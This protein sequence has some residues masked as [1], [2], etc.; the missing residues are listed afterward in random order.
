M[1]FAVTEYAGYTPV[2]GLLNAQV[3]S[4]TQLLQ[5]NG[6]QTTLGINSFRYEQFKQPCTAMDTSVIGFMNT[7][8]TAKD[9]IQSA[10]NSSNFLTYPKFYPTTGDAQTAVTQQFETQLSTV[11][12]Y[13]NLNWVGTAVT[14]AVSVSPGT[15]VSSS[16]GAT[17]V[18][19]FSATSQIGIAY[20]VIVKSVSG[21]FGVG[22]TVYLGTVPG[23]GLAMTTPS[24]INYVGTGGVYDDNT[25]VTFYPDLEPPNISV[26]SPF[27]NL[28]LKILNNS[29]KGLGV[30][31]T[32]W[33]NSLTGLNVYGSFVDCDD[34][35]V[36][37][38][39]VYAFNTVS[40]V[41]VKNTI[42]S[43]IVDVTANR[44]GITSYAN[45]SSVIKGYKRGYASN[46][47]A[48]TKTNS[49]VTTSVAD[50]EA[51]IIILSD[52]AFGGP[53]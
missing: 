47:W 36:K 13:H 49:K 21:N 42:N 37:T 8:N 34:P 23:A 35:I 12:V 24:F 45:S 43:L 1:G 19:A 52:P 38:G 18:V 40:G 14:G 25:I 26:G 33:P 15:A 51:A 46:M 28:Q 2:I 50:L 9:S 5:L 3:V 39:D 53:Y 17:G 4:K 27:S 10:G 7:I 30:A 32:F 16:T 31:N 11:E 44:T 29:M 6:N 48:M 20:S 41:T 22:G